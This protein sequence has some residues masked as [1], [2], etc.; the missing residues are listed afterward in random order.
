MEIQKFDIEGL[1]LIKPKVIVDS[2]GYFFE[3]FNKKKFDAAVGREVKFIQDNESRSSR[4]VLRGLHFQKPPFSQ[5]KLVRVIQGE[6]LDVTV[7]LRSNSTTYQMHQ[8]FLLSGDNKHQVYI[9][10]GFAHGFLVL[11]ES[12][13]F[14]YKVDSPYSPTHDTG[15]I[16]NDNILGIDWR[17]PESD[18]ILSDKDLYLQRVIDYQKS[19]LF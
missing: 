16:Y 13:I 12:A 4:G 15:I 3:S 11:S 7:D 10:K 8:S 6:V 9:P 14:A 18:L 19:P 5:A 2:R 17:L 1:L